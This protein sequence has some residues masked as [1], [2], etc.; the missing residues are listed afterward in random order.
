MIAFVRTAGIAPGKTGAVM[1]F[2]K[3][4]A[5]YFKTHYDVEL[6]VLTPIGGNPQRIAWSSRYK[7][8]SAVQTLLNK[9]AADKGY[10]ELVNKNVDCFVPGSLN[11]AF[12][13][14]V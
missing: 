9:M 6:T 7:D 12:W 8:L 5:A 4:I 11:D 2:A 3:E 14:E 13:Q 10:W 1:A